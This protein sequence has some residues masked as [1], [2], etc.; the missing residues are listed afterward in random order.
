METP[1][2]RHPKTKIG[3]LPTGSLPIAPAKGDRA[4][5]INDLE[6]KKVKRNSQLFPKFLDPLPWEVY[7]KV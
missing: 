5:N 3:S 4:D 7:H 2:S 6:P 1:M